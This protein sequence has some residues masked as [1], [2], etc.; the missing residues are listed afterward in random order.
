MV[1]TPKQFLAYHAKRTEAS[2]ASARFK[3]VAFDETQ[4]TEARLRAANK[5]SELA[6]A[7]TSAR[8]VQCGR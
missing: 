7:I 5:M 8:P 4:L 6:R 3:R 2:T 1:T